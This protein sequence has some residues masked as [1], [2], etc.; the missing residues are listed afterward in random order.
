[1]SKS[2]VSQSGFFAHRFAMSPPP[3]VVG[4]ERVADLYRKVEQERNGVRSRARAQLDDSD[5]ETEDLDTERDRAR[6]K[7]VKRLD[8]VWTKLS[9]MFWV[10][11]AIVMIWYTNFFRVIW[12][13][14]LVNRPYFNIA[15]ACLFFNISL[16]AYVVIWCN[17]I[18]GIEEPWE[19]YCPRVAP[20]MAVAGCATG[21]FFLMALWRVWGF[22]TILIQLTLF[23]GFLNSGHFLPSGGLGALLMFAIFFGAFFT[24]EM[25]PHEGMAH[26]MHAR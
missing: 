26:Y 13:S 2:S 7:W 21:A 25:I 5:S 6:K 9:A 3:R 18:L 12:E 22:L 16:L 14:P 4:R 23:L 1:V 17:M 19:T 15:F 8:W 24:S 20:V 11:S 10:G